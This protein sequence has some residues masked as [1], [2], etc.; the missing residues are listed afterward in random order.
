MYRTRILISSSHQFCTAVKES[1]EEIEEFLT[2]I[3][4]VN[5]NIDD[6]TYYRIQTYCKHLKEDAKFSPF[7]LFKMSNSIFISILATALTYM[8][9]MVQFKTTELPLKA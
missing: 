8:V 4:I 2:E 3:P 6:Y 9:V 7:N 1:G 5:A